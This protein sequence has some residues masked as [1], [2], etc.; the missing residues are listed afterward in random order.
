[1]Y[2]LKALMLAVI[3]LAMTAC[4]HNTPLQW[5]GFHPD[6]EGSS[7]ELKGKKA[8]IITTS[9]DTLGEGEDAEPTGVASS[10]VTHPYYE[11]QDNGLHVDLASIKGGK[12]P[13]DP[14]TTKFPVISPHDERAYEDPTYLQKINHSL[15]IDDIDF[16]KY[17]VVFLA[18]GWGAAYDLGFSDILGKKMSQ[19]YAAGRVVGGV[20][21][22]PLGLLKARNSK[23]ESLIKGRKLTA[24]TDK[25]VKELGIETTPLHPETELR[26]AGVIF[27]SKTAFKDI[28]AT[29]VV[30]DGTIVTGQNQNSGIETAH[31]M[32][33]I[34]AKQ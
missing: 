34:I 11:F 5:M 28:F 29:H 23:G 1:M 18:G 24:V 10:E 17:D 16:A 22:G 3:A 21:H 8:L 31:K 33:A 2:K 14:L 12:I 26:K 7:Y 13:V 15:K 32:M 9:H 30:V 19:A 4:A 20:C 27:E 6:Y 25:Q